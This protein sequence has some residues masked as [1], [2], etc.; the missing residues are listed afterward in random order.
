MNDMLGIDL[1]D[2]DDF[3][4]STLPMFQIFPRAIT[5]KFKIYGNLDETIEKIAS[6]MKKEA[7][8]VGFT[9]FGVSDINEMTNSNGKKLTEEAR[10]KQIHSKAIKLIRNDM[11][12]DYNEDKPSYDL[13]ESEDS[14]IALYI[15]YNTDSAQDTSK[16]VNFSRKLSE[17]NKDG[18]MAS[19][20]QRFLQSLLMLYFKTVIIEDYAEK[21]HLF[22]SGL[23]NLNSDIHRLLKITELPDDGG[24]EYHTLKPRIKVTAYNEVIVKAVYQKYV[25]VSKISDIA[26]TNGVEFF[27]LPST[28]KSDYEK[29]IEHSDSN[30]LVKDN[31]NKG[32]SAIKFV[33]TKNA[34]NCTLFYAS[35]FAHYVDGFLSDS[36]VD[37]KW[38]KFEPTKRLAQ[39]VGY[40]QDEPKAPVNFV[41]TIPDNI[42]DKKRKK[43]I[44]LESMDEGVTVNYTLRKAVEAYIRYAINNY[45]SDYQTTITFDS[46]VKYSDLDPNTDYIFIQ[47]PE[48]YSGYWFYH[49]KEKLDELK[50]NDECSGTQNL[51]VGFSDP[52]NYPS[53]SNSFLSIFD[54]AV[55][56][57]EK[58]PHFLSDKYTMLKVE[59]MYNRLY[60]TDKGRDIAMQ[61]HHIKSPSAMSSF[62][63]SEQYPEEQY[64]EE[65]KRFVGDKVNS[66]YRSIHNKIQTDLMSKRIINSNATLPLVDAKGGQVR[67][68]QVDGKYRGYFISRPRNNTKTKGLLFF[69]SY[70]DIKVEDGLVTILDKGVK[71]SESAVVADPKFPIGRRVARKLLN[72]SFYIIDEEGN[73]L[74]CYTGDREP[75]ALSGL[76]G[77]DT[78][79]D[80]VARKY[81]EGLGREEPI[82]LTQSLK[83]EPAPFLGFHLISANKNKSAGFNERASRTWI[84]I[85]PQDTKDFLMLATNKD[86][87]NQ[88][89][90]KTNRVYRMLVKDSKGNTLEAMQSKLASLYLQTTTY[91]INNASNYSFRS[92]LHTL[93]K[94]VLHN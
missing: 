16:L 78:I 71:L 7:W 46:E 60:D 45:Y 63:F 54:K 31:A 11:G 94:A 52:K 61:G 19:Q 35:L 81:T 50:K 17:V 64:P 42:L 29:Y 72:D 15:N 24:F 85:E 68:E 56:D 12:L 48:P 82:P 38:I 62:Y 20:K 77:E 47:E 69:A 80:Y 49:T 23:V 28:V 25:T 8:H 51:G 73:A 65:A 74:V 18:F 89:V 76:D 30:E 3:K 36:D 44:T 5:N 92:V 13:F 22:K 59:H 34:T 40:S 9:E 14:C 75:Q 2:I 6:A 26:E 90:S 66:T 37:Y 1:E 21:E 4:D 33:D 32:S 43:T 58:N 10:Q 41:V 91:N 57:A 83:Q 53:R 88:N 70:L 67:L 55:I 27:F 93:T 39:F 87:L 84:Y 79:V 86:S